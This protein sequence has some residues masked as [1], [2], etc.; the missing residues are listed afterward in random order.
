MK[1]EIYDHPTPLEH[2]LR[3]LR[4]PIVELA[5]VMLVFIGLL[6]VDKGPCPRKKWLVE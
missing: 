1:T 4:P 2:Q 5:H 3:E 6:A